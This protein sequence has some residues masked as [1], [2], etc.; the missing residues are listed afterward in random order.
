MAISYEL[1]DLKTRNAVGG[2][3]TEAEALD[4]VRRTIDANGP[5][6]ANDLALLRVTA[7]G[8]AK[9]VAVG[10]A[11]ADRAREAAPPQQRISV[12]A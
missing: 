8:R 9:P 10:A 5:E 4:V 1:W 2:Y 12:S 11:L 3:S 7:H 6:F